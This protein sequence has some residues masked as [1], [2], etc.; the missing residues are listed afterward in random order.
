[1]AASELLTFTLL[2]LSSIFLLISCD[3]QRRSTGLTNFLLQHLC[4]IKTK[5]FKADLPNSLMLIWKSKTYVFW[6]VE[7]LEP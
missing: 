7:I 1:V 5:V 2:I 4:L 3:L 6:R